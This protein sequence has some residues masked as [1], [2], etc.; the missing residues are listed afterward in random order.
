[1]NA[2]RFDVARYLATAGD[3]DTAEL[4]ALPERYRAEMRGY[5]GRGVLPAAPLRRLLEGDPL[6][7]RLF[8]DDLPGFAALVEW[9]ASMLP[10]A[11]W[12]SEAQVGLWTLYVRRAR[13]RALL[14]SMEGPTDAHDAPSEAAP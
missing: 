1:M 9:I 12:G 3:A 6:A 5:L 7:V 2:K 8:A 13:G 10:A 14:A 11:C 4:G